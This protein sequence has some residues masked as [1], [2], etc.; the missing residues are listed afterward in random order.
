MWELNQDQHFEAVAG[1]CPLPQ[2]THSMSN[3]HMIQGRIGGALDEP[4]F[5]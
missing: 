2:S 5:L 4:I 1:A 3:A